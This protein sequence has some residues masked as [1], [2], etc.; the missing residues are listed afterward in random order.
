MQLAQLSQAL[1]TSPPDYCNCLMI[2]IPSIQIECLQK[3][4]NKAA[5][6]ILRVPSHWHISPALQQ[7]HW[8]PV[9][10]RINYKVLVTLF[11]SMH[12]LAPTHLTELLET[13]QQDTWLWHMDTLFLHQPMTRKHVGEQAFGTAAPHLWNSLSAQIWSTTALSALNTALKTYLFKQYFGC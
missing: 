9:P 12:A 11:K 10:C 5:R 2:N 3:I 7:I 1:I 13:R 4:Q 6:M 8:L